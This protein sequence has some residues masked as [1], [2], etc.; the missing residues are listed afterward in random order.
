MAARSLETSIVV[1]APRPAVFRWVSDYHNAPI[2]LEGVRRW[3]PLDPARTTG[4][5][6]R[7][8]VRIAFFGV[9]AGTT[10]EMD[11][12]NPPDV[13]AW[14]AD[15]GPVDVR[16]RWTFADH[17]AGT[18]VTLFLEYDPP[19][20]LL[21]RFGADRLSGLGRQRLEDGLEAMREAI[22]DEEP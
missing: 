20:G 3:E 2:A 6:A 22:E 14:H 1:R 16:G 8:S 13:I 4:A 18:S 9:T 10:L 5:G 19:G 17:P 15:G 11:T 21:G 12:W 7:F